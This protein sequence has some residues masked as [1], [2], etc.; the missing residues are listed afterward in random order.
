MADLTLFQRAF[1]RAALARQSAREAI[2]A[3][4]LKVERGRQLSVIRGKL[5]A[6]FESADGERKRKRAR[7]RAELSSAR[8]TL[9]GYREG[10]R[11]YDL[12]R[13][14]VKIPFQ[15]FSSASPTSEVM[16]AVRPARQLARDVVRNDPIGKHAMRLYV[17]QWWGTGITPRC[18]ASDQRFPNVKGRLAINRRFLRA[19][20]KHAETTKI[21]ADGKL[22]YYGLMRLAIRTVGESGEVLIIKRYRSRAFCERRGLALPFQL[23]VLEADWLNDRLTSWTTR[24]GKVN[25]VVGGVELD[26]VDTVVAYHI[27]VGDGGN[28]DSPDTTQKSIRFPADEVIHYFN[29]DRPGQKRGISDFA[30]VLLMLYDL[31]DAFGTALQRHK[32][33]NALMLI[34]GIVPGSSQ[35]DTAVGDNGWGDGADDD[36]TGVDPTKFAGSDHQTDPNSGKLDPATPIAAWSGMGVDPYGRLSDGDGLAIET[37]R[38]GQIG[39]V[40]KGTD[41]NTVQPT[42]SVNLEGFLAAGMRRVAAGTGLLYEALSGDWSK[43]NFSASRMAQAIF[44]TETDNRQWDFMVRVLQPIY[45]MMVQGGYTMSAWY[46]VDARGRSLPKSQRTYWTVDELEPEDVRWIF[47]EKPVSDVERDA[48]AKSMRMAM[49]ELLWQDMI[50]AQGK[51]PREVIIE[52]AEFREYAAGY[53]VDLDKF[54]DAFAKNVAGSASADQDDDAEDDLDVE[55]EIQ[56]QP[57]QEDQVA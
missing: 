48:K 20:K 14:D 44:W 9:L 33:E 57:D 30:Q 22:D 49:R 32:L 26:D 38:S 5:L 15:N 1:P 6:E 7:E 56:D 3:S 12:A 55:P 28:T 27:L 21:D 39:R 47:P 54:Q 17:N 24:G 18:T 11:G 10:T 19:W 46:D 35:E 50:E 4:Q 29:V 52:M 8:D 37:I 41:V 34:L 42:P 40:P 13:P 23:Q 16:G 31:A 25:R 36:P 53:G 45:E 51:D 43:S 2:V